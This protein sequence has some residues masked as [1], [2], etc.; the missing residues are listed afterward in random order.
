MGQELKEIPLKIESTIYIL[1]ENKDMQ[2][3]GDSQFWQQQDHLQEVKGNKHQIQWMQTDP[4]QECQIRLTSSR[5][6][7]SETCSRI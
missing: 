2:N 7:L 5:N 4:E 1:N 6:H 3:N